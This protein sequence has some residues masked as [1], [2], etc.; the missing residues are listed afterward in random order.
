MAERRA[1]PDA[2]KANAVSARDAFLAIK[3]ETSACLD[4]AE[5]VENDPWKALA[6]ITA[7]LGNIGIMAAKGM[8]DLENIK[9]MDSTIDPSAAQLVD[10]KS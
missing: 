4:I 5:N 10:K 9:G 7:K 1:I 8:R 6:R 3:A 2:A